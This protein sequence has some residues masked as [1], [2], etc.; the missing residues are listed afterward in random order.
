MVVVGNLVRVPELFI[1]TTVV[2]T[3][4]TES[5]IAY[6]L[7]QCKLFENKLV[8]KKG[9]KKEECEGRALFLLA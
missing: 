5:E 3:V 8:Y 6:S 9:R 7:I 2:F 4:K 1:Y